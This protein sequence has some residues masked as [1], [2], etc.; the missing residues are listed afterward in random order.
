MVRTHVYD[1]IS[2]N[3]KDHSC[4]R[5]IDC[6]VASGNGKKSKQM[7][8]T[9]ANNREDEKL[10]SR[11]LSKHFRYKADSVSETSTNVAAVVTIPY[12]LFFYLCISPLFS[13]CQQQ[14][15]SGEGERRVRK[16]REGKKKEKREQ[17]ENEIEGMR[18]TEI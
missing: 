6:N 5:G 9:I 12:F 17:R 7:R 1:T 16:G 4:T 14:K 11:F 3:D 2:K 13:K 8:E 10:P 18:K 15:L